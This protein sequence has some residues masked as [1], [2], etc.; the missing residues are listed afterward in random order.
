MTKKP[1]KLSFVIGATLIGNTLEWYDLVTFGF[2]IPTFSKIFFPHTNV[3][4]SLTYTMVALVCGSLLRPIG[5]LIF[6][7]IGD[8]YGRRIALVTSILLMTGPTLIIG[9]LPT[10]WQIGLAAPLTLLAMRLLQSLA[11]GGE[12][13]G[14]VTYLYEASP[15]NKRVFFCSFTYFGVVLGIFGGGLDF[16]FLTSI[17]TEAEFMERGWRSIFFLGALLGVLA[18]FMRRKLHET[19]GFKQLRESHEI[20]Q[21]P[22]KTLFSRY[23]SRIFKLI[24][25]EMAETIAFNLIIPFFITY[26]IHELHVP[27]TEAVQL[28]TLC[29]VVYVLFI[30]FA[31]L[32]AAKMGPKKMLSFAAYGLLVFSIPLYYMLQHPGLRIFTMIGL[33]L[34]HASYMAAIPTLY[35]ELFPT[36]VRFSGVGIAFNLVVGLVGGFVPFLALTLIHVTGCILIPPFFLMIGALISLFTLRRFKNPLTVS[37]QI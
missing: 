29:L 19:P 36:V 24:G 13:P 5:G 10:Y 12:F 16:F 35:C 30:P 17:Y 21:D 20:L 15:P 14:A 37:K 27:F 3:W 7:F 4:L 34:L 26:L 8:R 33:P 25:I 31:G 32:L 6:G 1:L 18:F 23:K 2:L 28:N 9:I 11:V 22:I